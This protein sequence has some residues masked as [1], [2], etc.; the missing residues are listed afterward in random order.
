MRQEDPFRAIP[1]DPRGYAVC[2]TVLVYDARI[3]HEVLTG[4]VDPGQSVR[5][6]RERESTRGQQM[7]IEDKN[8]NKQRE[9]YS[10]RKTERQR[11]RQTNKERGRQR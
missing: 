8:E 9:R 1:T 10:S 7:G 6:E 11:Q 2:C 5:E 3:K 4:Y